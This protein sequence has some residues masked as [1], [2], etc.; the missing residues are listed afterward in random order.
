MNKRLNFYSLILLFPH[1]NCLK[2][3]T[4]YKLCFI[5]EKKIN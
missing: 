4:A 3:E 2:N 5:E 1:E